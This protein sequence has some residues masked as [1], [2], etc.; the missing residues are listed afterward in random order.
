MELIATAR[1]NG[2]AVAYSTGA[3]FSDDGLRL[4]CGLLFVMR[5]QKTKTL[6][7][8]CPQTQERVR[9]R[10]PRELLGTRAHVL[11]RN[12]TLEVIK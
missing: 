8:R 4:H 3:A 10:L 5:H 7:L 2:Q 12:Y 1:R 11:G 6:F 9:V